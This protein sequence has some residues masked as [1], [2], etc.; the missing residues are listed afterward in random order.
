MMRTCPVTASIGI[1]A[2]AHV[3]YE[4]CNH[5][6]F[7]LGTDR[8]EIARRQFHIMEPVLLNAKGHSVSLAR[9]VAASGASS[10]AAEETVVDMLEA[11]EMEEKQEVIAVDDN[12]SLQ[13]SSLSLASSQN[14]RPAM[15]R[16]GDIDVLIVED[17]PNQQALLQCAA[18]SACRMHLISQ[19]PPSH[20]RTPHS[21]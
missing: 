7:F 12:A 14:A 6:A 3:L 15:S 19:A 17:D 9:S 13:A 10:D 18:S 16:L 4:I 8:R 1:H 2:H 20:R 11:V 5:E 21:I